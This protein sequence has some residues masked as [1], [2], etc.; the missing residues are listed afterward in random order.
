M[1]PK[2]DSWMLSLPQ[3]KIN[4]LSRSSIYSESLG[5]NLFLLD[6]KILKINL[7]VGS[8]HLS[9][10]VR[11]RSIQLDNGYSAGG[12]MDKYN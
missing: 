9:V 7:R 8:V 3:D 12:N 11:D 5:C 4:L 10:D 2:Y 1:K 6:V